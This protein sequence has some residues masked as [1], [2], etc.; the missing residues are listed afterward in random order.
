MA[1][2][3]ALTP[4]FKKQNKKQ[5]TNCGQFLLTVLKYS[6]PV[7]A[8]ASAISFVVATQAMGCPLPMGFPIVTM[9]GINSSP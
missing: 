9:S 5:N 3:L 4:V 6:T 2:I 7:A 8:N 1:L